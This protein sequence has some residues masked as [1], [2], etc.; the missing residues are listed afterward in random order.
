VKRRDG[1]RASFVLSISNFKGNENQSKGKAG[2]HLFDI[3]FEGITVATMAGECGGLITG[4]SVGIS[5]GKIAYVGE[6]SDALEAK[7][8][9]SG[10]DK[11]MVPGLYNCH[12]HSPMV[13][14]RGYAG[15][16]PLQEWLFGCI[17][18]AEKRFPPEAPYAG[19]M[20]AMAEMISSGIVSFSDMY[21]GLESIARAVD[22][23]GMKVNLSNALTAFGDGFDY[24]KDRSYLETAAVLA[25]YAKCSHGRIKAE[26]GIHGEYTS[27]PR[28]WLQ[29]SEF[30][31]ERGLRMHI[32]LSET[33][34]EHWQCKQ[35]HG[36]TPAQ[37]LDKSHVFDVPAQAAHCVWVEEEDMELLKARNVTVVHNPVSNLKLASG[38]APV[39]KMLSMGINVALGTDGVASNNSHDL[40]EEIK[41]SSLLQKS[42]TGDPTV[43][44]AWEALSLATVNGAKCQG[45]DAESGRI[46][47]GLDADIA[48]LDFHSPRQA[49]SRDPLGNV[50]YSCTG[51]DV[52][53]TMCQGN[54][55]YENGEHKTI[56]V[57]KAMH[58][59]KRLVGP[60]LG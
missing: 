1:K 55:L 24:H 22:E 4:A 38:V 51:R 44:P 28:A 31:L 3:L 18:P 37:A 60:I 25:G 45:R 39:A 35:R 11:V 54:I 58:E 26:A 29:A 12:A 57:E 20:L 14:L 6:G 41:M 23:A 53:L 15:D 56:D 46:E 40:F 17:I 33:K 30:A 13:L 59:A 10:K 52:W 43:L 32:H 50:A 2:A 36:L 42:L 19:A 9:I 47:K 21:F 49:G 48:V 16:K 27:N 5:G 7:R 34:T 8:V